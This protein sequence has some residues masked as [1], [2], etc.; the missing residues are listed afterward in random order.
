MKARDDIAAE[1]LGCYSGRRGP[2]STSEIDA[3]LRE[4]DRR[5]E[6]RRHVTGRKRARPPLG[7]RMKDRKK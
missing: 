1:I 3:A 6:G 2:F 5:M 4:A 7:Q